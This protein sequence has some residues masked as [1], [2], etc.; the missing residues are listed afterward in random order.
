[1][2]SYRI[3]PGKLLAAA[4]AVAALVTV[5]AV[6]GSVVA[7]SAHATT[8]P[9]PHILVNVSITDTTTKLSKLHVADVNYVDFFLHNTGKLAH[10]FVIGG[11]KSLVLKPGT[12]EHFFVGFPVFGFYP[13]KTTLN[14]KPGMKGRFKVDSPEPPD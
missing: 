12:R 7:G 10:N 3:A 9:A 4:A 11:Q 8:G 2:R 6:G 13:Y 1:M 5:A 14:G